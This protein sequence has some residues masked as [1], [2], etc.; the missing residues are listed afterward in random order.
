M[1]RVMLHQRVGIGIGA[2][3]AVAVALASCGG[4]RNLDA[5]TES[6]R[7]RILALAPAETSQ[8]V[9]FCTSWH[10]DGALSVDQF[11][12]ALPMQPTSAT[13]TAA[14]ITFAWWN[15]D[16]AEEDDP[17][18]GFEL[19]CSAHPIRGATAITT[20]LWYRDTPMNSGG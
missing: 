18:P 16:H 11:P 2:A 4:S 7:K 6:A 20:G 5:R 13:A 8:I 9:A 14:A 12:S 10:Q 1:T 3:L 19:I 17:H 15:N